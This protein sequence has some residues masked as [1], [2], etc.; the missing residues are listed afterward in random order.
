[1][2]KTLVWTIKFTERQLKIFGKFDKD[3]Q[4]NARFLIINVICNICGEIVS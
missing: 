2:K 3:I 1:M 4:R